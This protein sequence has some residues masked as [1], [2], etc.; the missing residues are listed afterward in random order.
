MREDERG[1][2][3]SSFPLMGKVAA[4]RPDRVKIEDFRLRRA[5]TPPLRGTSPIKGEEEALFLVIPDG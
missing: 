4:Q 2:I 3:S 1:R 5:P